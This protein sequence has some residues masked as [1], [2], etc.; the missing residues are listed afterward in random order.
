MAETAEIGS[1]W[2]R[3]AYVASVSSSVVLDTLPLECDQ[4]WLVM[5]FITHL[6]R[7]VSTF[8]L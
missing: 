7:I 1:L 4:A 8:V 2:R 6:I 5:A 3:I